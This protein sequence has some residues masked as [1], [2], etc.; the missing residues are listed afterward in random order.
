MK[1]TANLQTWCEPEVVALVDSFCNQFHMFPPKRSEMA[2]VLV[3]FAVSTINQKPSILK[4]ICRL[5]AE[6]AIA[7]IDE[8]ETYPAKVEAALLR[9]QAVRNCS[10]QDAFDYIFRHGITQAEMCA[11]QDAQEIKA[12]RLA[13]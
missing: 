1:K 3:C 12:E 10:R 2:R 5:F 4:A 6:R 13:G 11:F 8:I 9:C 7:P